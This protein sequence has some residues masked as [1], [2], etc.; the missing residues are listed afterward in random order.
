MNQA[1]IHTLLLLS[2]LK[3]QVNLLKRYIL[4]HGKIIKNTVLANKIMLVLETTM[5][6]GLTAK[7][8]EKES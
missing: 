2:L 4:E 7:K 6:T 5:E 3:M 8:M 1:P